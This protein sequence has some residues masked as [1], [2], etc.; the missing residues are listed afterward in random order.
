[1]RVTSPTGTR[2]SLGRGRHSRFPRRRTGRAPPGSGCSTE[3]GRR[4]DLRKKK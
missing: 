4:A 2:R 1:M 3:P